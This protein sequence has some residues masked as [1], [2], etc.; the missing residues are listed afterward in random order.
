MRYISSIALVLLLTTVA[1]PSHAQT[2]NILGKRTKIV[3]G[4][5]QFGN[6]LRKTIAVT[7]APL[8]APLRY[9]SGNNCTF[10][11][12]WSRVGFADQNG[13]MT[14]NTA[15]VR[16]RVAIS[17]HTLGTQ[18]SLLITSNGSI[19]N[20]NSV[21]PFTRERVTAS[22]LAAAAEKTIQELQKKHPEAKN[23]DFIVGLPM[24]P[25][26]IDNDGSVGSK[27]AV[28]DSVRG[29][30]AAYYYQGMVR[31]R[32]WD[33]AV[34]DLIQVVNIKGK[35]TNVRLGFL[36]A[37][38]RTMMPLMFVF[39]NYDRIRARVIRCDR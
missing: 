37:E 12:F 26:L 11:L 22:N 19:T 16:D 32:N 10:E 39:E 17:M 30:W 36:V 20:F 23:P 4:M 14:I 8:P 33:G 3:G 34:L 25:R 6:L 29:E 13:A 15:M 28:V 2:S 35:P 18:S 27:V 31:Y 7:A 5:V 38:Y 24:L 1:G 21:D 9:A